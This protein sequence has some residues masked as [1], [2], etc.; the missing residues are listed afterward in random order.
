MPKEGVTR[1]SRVSS[2]CS[3][4][5]GFVVVAYVSSI[6]QGCDT[7][8]L[9]SQAQDYYNQYANATA[10]Y[11]ASNYNCTTYTDCMSI[12][13][14]KA[15]DQ[16]TAAQK[17]ATVHLEAAQAAMA[18]NGHLNATMA[19]AVASADAAAQQASTAYQQVSAQASTVINE[20]AGDTAAGAADTRLYEESDEEEDEGSRV[21]INT[22]VGAMLG[23]GAFGFVLLFAGR[24]VSVVRLEE[25][26]ELFDRDEEASMD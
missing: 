10:A 6:L 14:T 1:D 3:G 23:V 12:L 16:A 17:A 25:E 8:S 15:Q 21:P 2:L 9:K 26:A 5:C 4:V 13:Q 18:S 20:E 19:A 22:A 7:T 24:R 11:A